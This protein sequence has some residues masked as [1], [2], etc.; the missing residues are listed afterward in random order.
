MAGAGTS[1]VRVLHVDDNIEFADTAAAFL[2]RADP[3]FRVETTASVATALEELADST[4]DCIVSD[5]NMPGRD[6]I[7]FLRAVREEFPDLPFI[8]FTGKGS[9]AIAS[10]AIS[11]GVT[12]YLQK[13][14]TTEQYTLLANRIENA[15][16]ARR[17]A[18]RADRQR[19]LLARSEVLGS[20]GGWELTLETEQLRMTAGLKHLYGLD[21]GES[22]SLSEA[23]EVYEAAS[24]STIR[25]MIN[26]A[27]KTGYAEET[28]LHFETA[29]GERRVAEGNAELVDT[30]GSTTV[31]RGV[32]RD[33]TDRYER[34]RELEILQQAI[35]DADVSITLA[36]PSRPDAP[37]VYVNDAFEELT[38]YSAE[39]ALGRNWRFLQG[40][41]TDPETVDRLRRAIAEEE[42]TTVEMRT[43][44]A[45]GTAFW[46]RLTVT[47]I[48]DSDGELLR[49]LGTQ[50]DVTERR[51]R[52][53]QLRDLNRV[54]Q[55][56]SSARTEQEIATIGVDAAE[57][58]LDLQATGIHLYSE[59]KTTL[60][61]TAY[62]PDVESLVGEPP[63]LPLK[64]SIAGRVYRSGEPEIVEH[65][66][67][68]PDVYN[69][70]S[71]A[72]GHYYLPLGDHGVLIASSTEPNA[73]DGV[74]RT[75][76]ELLAGNLVAAF[77]RVSRAALARR[78]REQLSVF[79]AQSPLGAVQWDDEF[80]FER[81]NSRAEEILGYD[82]SDIV[83]ESWK[84][85]VPE[86]ETDRIGNLV[87]KLRDDDGG[88][89]II[90]TN[91]RGDG[92]TITCEWYNRA[93][94]NDD[95]SVRSIFS[96]FRDVTDRE[97]R[98]RELRQ[99]ETIIDA[100]GD[101]VYV[102]DEDDQFSY[103]N[104]AFLELVGY[105]RE[106]VVGATPDL[107]ADGDSVAALEQRLADLRSPE[108]PDTLTFEMVVQPQES[109]PVVCE[110]Y[111]GVLSYEAGE[112]AGSVG[113]LRDISDQKARA[114]EMRKLSSQYQT[115]VEHFPDGGVFLFDDSLTNVRAGGEELTE[116]GLTSGDVEGSTPH[117]LFPD[118]IADELVEYYRKALDGESHTFRQQYQGNHY[119]VK[120]MPI[121]TAGDVAYG[122]AVSRNVTDEVERQRELQRQND[123]LEEFVQ[124]VSHDLRN[125]LHVADG[126]LELAREECDS[127]YLAN[128]TNALS[129]C[130]TMVEDLLTLARD[131][132]TVGQREPVSLPDICQNCW[133]V[134]P[135]ADATLDIETDMRVSA[136]PDR[137]R[138]V[139]ENLFSNAVEHGGRDVSV[140]VGETA[141]GF[142]VADD[143]AGLPDEPTEALFESGHSGDSEGTGVG[144]RIVE[145]VVSAH[146]WTVTAT[147]NDAG[148]AR[149]EITS[150][151]TVS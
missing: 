16:Q 151:D 65:V 145:Q 115:L 93:V 12:D 103:V 2:E 85:I 144:L 98:K 116:V 18:Q 140:T 29:E 58:I 138:A 113:I 105:D 141:D 74:D 95:G 119:Q 22:L 137:L 54:A 14:S 10:E 132:E 91:V 78:R 121:E 24:Q 23:I 62:T 63:A 88:R 99:Y 68:D 17:D 123:R 114:A 86:E 28:E 135:T 76:G 124:I 75:A 41:E 107:I 53:T 79:F 20:M 101:A 52:E 70:G 94:T 133:Q 109:D 30:D 92:E 8:L 77:D 9:E 35:D 142:Y 127:P 19:D 27:V 90:N 25:Q 130:Q 5:Y 44:R 47:P 31:L 40:E 82:E 1:P 15:V 73:F 42:Q 57:E 56:L 46:N 81:L 43:Y 48:Y 129:R 148:G 146:G 21:E 61:P 55:D 69:E 50:F 4:P 125:P 11:A 60:E 112:T 37:L 72:T 84:R 100:L 96:M 126:N 89:N 67:A 87:Q 147:E 3:R 80:N 120:I 64:D 26:D 106:Q 104:D 38:G 66:S 150:V 97:R 34:Q 45:D 139:F 143:G 49:Y 7:E 111:T 13:E 122:M 39:V 108:R 118:E 128:A 33:I 36:D 32:V 136:D 59:D 6:G 149:F 134:V 83:G 131:G 110:N 71:T 51:E 102:L 117:D